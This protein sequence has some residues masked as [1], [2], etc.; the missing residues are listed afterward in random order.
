[1]LDI[2]GV[3]GVSPDELTRRNFIPVMLGLLVATI[4]AIF[5]M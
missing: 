2:S 1:V 4:V 5:L 3:T